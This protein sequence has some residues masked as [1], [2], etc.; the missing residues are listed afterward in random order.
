MRSQAL[1]VAGLRDGFSVPAL[2]AAMVQAQINAAEDCSLRCCRAP[3]C[4]NQ[5]NVEA[6]D[7][8]WARMNRHSNDLRCGGRAALTPTGVHW[9]IGAEHQRDRADK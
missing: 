3:R 5:W 2:E 6:G 8:G 1:L 4:W 9:P 7:A